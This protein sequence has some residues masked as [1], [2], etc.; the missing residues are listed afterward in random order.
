PFSVVLSE[1]PPSAA[2]AIFKRA[3]TFSHGEP[4]KENSG[5]W[6]VKEITNPVTSFPAGAYQSVKYGLTTVFP[7]RL[8]H[9]ETSFSD[10]RKRERFNRDVQS[11]VSRL[12]PSVSSGDLITSLRNL[13]EITV[14]EFGS[15]MPR[16]TLTE[17][18]E[19]LPRSISLTAIVNLLR[20]SD[21]DIRYCAARVIGQC[22][23]FFVVR[24]L[25]EILQDPDA[26]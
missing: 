11:I 18:E 9:D 2:M 8:H 1:Y 13:L 4:A 25:E 24:Q 3:S 5:A 6:T 22:G 14:N 15:E 12:T 19:R 7:N 10:R 17:S 21:P 23:G 16:G 20:N 26:I